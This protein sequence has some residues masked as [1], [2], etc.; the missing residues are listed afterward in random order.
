MHCPINVHGVLRVQLLEDPV[1]GNERPC[2]AHTSAAVHY[3]G[4]SP[5]ASVDVV[6]DCPHK[7][8]QGLGGLWD[9]MVWPH[10]VVKVTDESVCIQLFFTAYLKL[11]D[12][13]LGEHGLRDHL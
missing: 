13:P 8:D 10:R 7:L 5:G 4:P 9:P 3:G 1:Q 12:G 6:P 11:P 2:S